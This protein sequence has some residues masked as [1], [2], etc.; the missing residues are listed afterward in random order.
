MVFPHFPI[1]RRDKET[2]KVRIVF[3][4]SA[5]Y[6]GIS[7][8]NVIN[9]DPKLQENLTTVLLRFPSIQSQLSVIFKKCI[10]VSRL[11]NMTKA[12]LAFYGE[13]WTQIVNQMFKN[14]LTLSLGLIVHHF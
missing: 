13:T 8:N 12:T 2:T 4:A 1:V 9:A 14:F 3:G 10:N 5:T 6:K 11:I 7:L